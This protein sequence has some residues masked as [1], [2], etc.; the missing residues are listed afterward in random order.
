MRKRGIQKCAYLVY[1]SFMF[2]YNSGVES[3]VEKNLYRTFYDANILFR[4]ALTNA[5]YFKIPI[6][7]N[8]L[9]K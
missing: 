5:R 9:E 8:N 3:E 4:H 1:F 6:K 7:R 2:V